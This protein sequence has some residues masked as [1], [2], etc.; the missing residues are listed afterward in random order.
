MLDERLFDLG[1][2]LVGKNPESLRVE[3]GL[4]PQY[5][6]DDRRT[7][8]F[9][10]QFIPMKEGRAAEVIRVVRVDLIGHG[11]ILVRLGSFYEQ[12]KQCRAAQRVPA[13]CE[14]LVW[15]FDGT[16][17]EEMRPCRG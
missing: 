11:E 6:L 10:S 14:K 1:Q 3:A 9:R 16:T 7:S 2:C 17:I 8:F 12:V 4:G 15:F 5:F 13:I